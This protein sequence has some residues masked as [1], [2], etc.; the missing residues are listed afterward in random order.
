MSK[1]IIYLCRFTLLD[2]KIFCR[3]G[4]KFDESPDDVYL[5]RTGFIVLSIAKLSPTTASENSR[6]KP[7]PKLTQ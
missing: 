4:I 7:L 5:A 2:M 3:Q 6:A 1:K